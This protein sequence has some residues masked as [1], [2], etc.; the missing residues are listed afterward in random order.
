MAKHPKDS[1][2]PI[3]KAKSFCLG[4]VIKTADRFFYRKI[5]DK[6]FFFRAIGKNRNDDLGLGDDLDM[7]YINMEKVDRDQFVQYIKELDDTVKAEV[8]LDF[9]EPK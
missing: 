9:F 1:R 2:S 8:Y 6:V 3:V 4:E 5:D 7:Y